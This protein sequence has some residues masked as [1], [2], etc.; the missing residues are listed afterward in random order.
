MS[1]PTRQ[2]TIATA[3]AF[4]G[5]GLHSG[6]ECNAVI[7]PAT[8]GDGI[9][10]R[11]V[12]VAD[13]ENQIAAAPERVVRARHGTT[14]ANASGVSVSTIEHIMA[15]LALTNID[16]AIID[17]DGPEIPILDGS[18]AQFVQ[19]IA[20]AGIAPLD[21]VR[22]MASVHEPVKVTDNDRSVSIEPYQGR[23]IELEI[24]FEDCMIGRQHLSLDLDN[25]ADLVKLAT[26][27]TFCQL[28]EVEMLRAAGLIQGGGLTNSLVVDGDRILN[29]GPLRDP[30]EFA[31]HKALD[32]IGDLYLIGA[33]IEG[34]IRAK[35]PG[36]DLNTR[37]ALALSRRVFNAAPA[38][39][40][41]PLRASA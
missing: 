38:A 1:K 32:L 26:A 17:V 27:R 40:R 41:D 23:R 35:K 28:N 4:Q 3:V 15:A 34:L 8:A 18:A 16:N 33:P 13:T 22:R 37:A 36:H 9:I 10:F 11:R 20:E 2:H 19:A 21:A 14:I 29:D 5:I 12:D 6:I 31:L 24:E 30:A 39:G 7:N 25:P